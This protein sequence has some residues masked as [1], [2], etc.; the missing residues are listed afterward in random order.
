MDVR[1]RIIGYL[2]SSL[3]VLACAASAATPEDWQDRM[4][5]Q[6]NTYLDSHPDQR[7]RKQG[8][9]ALKAGRY[10]EAVRSFTR[11]AGYADKASQV[12][13]AEMYWDGHGVPQDRALAYA[14]MD[15]AAERGGQG[16]LARREH[17]WAALGPAE[18]TR[19][20]SLGKPLY[21]R[22]ADDVAQPRLE[23][24]MRATRQQVTGSHAGYVG[25]VTVCIRKEQVVHQNAIIADTCR[26][27]ASGEAFFADRLWEPARYW[28][29]Q[30]ELLQAALSPR[31]DVGPPNATAAPSSPGDRTAR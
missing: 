18:R 20:V 22:Y 1:S 28:A 8:L 13:L 23:R 4:I 9:N 7:L 26:N 19:A 5:R 25:D 24:N 16:V 14:W 11:A 29:R 31:V 27:G 17:Y 21:A 10:E 3:L 15:L 2:S 6:S 12:M 30:D